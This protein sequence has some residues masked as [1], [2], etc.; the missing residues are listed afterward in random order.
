MS[1]NKFFLQPLDRIAITILLFVFLLIWLLI[2]RG[3]IVQPSVREFSWENKR[4]GADEVSF[5]LTFS[6]PMDIKSVEENL[7][8]DPPLAG[9]FSWVGRRRMVYTLL[10]PAP[11]GTDYQVKL[12][13]AQDY[14]AAKAGGKKFI[15]PFIG[16]FSSRDRVILYIGAESNNQGRLIMYNLTRQQK[17]ILT[18]RDLVVTEFK[19]YS[20]REKILFTAH[21]A[22]NEDI[23]SAKL[24]TVTT[25]LSTRQN[26]KPTQP[27]QFKLT[28]DSEKYQILK[29]D[30]SPNG[31]TIVV[32]R[33]NKDNPSDFGLWFMSDTGG[34]SAKDFQKL[35]SQPGGDFIIT[36]DGQAVAISQGQGTAILPLQIDANKPL[37]FLPQFGLVKAFSKDGASAAMVKFNADYTRELFLV[38]NQGPQKQLFKTT[39]SILSCQFDSASPTIYWLLT[40]VLS[41]EIYQEQPYIVAINLRTGEQ[42]PLL[43]LPTG[44]NNIRMNLSPDGLGLLF[45]Q[46]YLQPTNFQQSPG[47]NLRTDGGQ[48]IASSQLWL[49]PLLPI[50]DLKSSKAITP[51]KLPLVGFNPQWLP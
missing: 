18:P 24:Y 35:E 23:L 17:Q 16:K 42:R 30:L 19:P 21:S 4:I 45:D 29:F 49:M 26:K 7:I 43:V 39:G 9:K 47:I 20:N 22:R 37:D 44:Q 6:R 28:L 51:D 5:G 33:G 36:P 11:Y 34:E 41:G 3:D 31:K 27:G 14:F 50:A 40:R 32:Q 10:T 15:Q 48:Q 13:K 1:I 8:I 46:V 25:G 12:Q 38:T 2:L